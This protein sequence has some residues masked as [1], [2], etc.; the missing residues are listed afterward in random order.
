MK[1]PTQAQLLRGSQM[2]HRILNILDE[3]PHLNAGEMGIVL[4]AAL[5]CLKDT[6]QQEHGS[7]SVVMMKGIFKIMEELV[8]ENA[9]DNTEIK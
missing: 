3:K 1:E 6:Y 2:A 7:Q 4:G 5:K 8:F 9:N